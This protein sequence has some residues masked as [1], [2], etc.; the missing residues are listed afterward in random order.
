MASAD[1]L[2]FKYRR[3][4]L[5]APPVSARHVEWSAIA[6]TDDEPSRCQ[7][8]DE[9]IL[10]A[11]AAAKRALNL[12]LNSV[13]ERCR[14]PLE[15]S[16]VNHWPGDHYRLL[17]AL[18]EVTGAT[19]AVEIG[20]HTGMGALALSH[21]AGSCTPRIVHTYDVVPWEQF[22]NT[23]F[24]ADDF[25]KIEQR[26]GDLANARFFFDQEEILR[27]ADLIFI[28]GPKDGVF[29]PMLVSL[30]LPVIRP[31]QV[32]VFDDIRKLEMLQIWRDLPLTKLDVTS[33]GHWSGT[34]L[35][36]A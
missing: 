16:W 26:I 11:L 33:F 34:G 23:L 14:T 27:S 28:D 17:A 10:L 19:Q 3:R 35:A 6:S 2:P 1:L 5:G 24:L 7:P 36:L 22:P 8:T 9:L 30:L 12:T 13:A 20:T 29:E 15:A 31:G 4:L 18:V 25:D 21:A 32:L